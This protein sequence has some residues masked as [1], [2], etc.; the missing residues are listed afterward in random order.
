MLTI[1]VPM[2]G[3]GSRFSTAGYKLP[4]P[5]I[6]VLGECMISR[7]VRNLAPYEPHRFVFIA[8]REHEPYIKKHMSFATNVVYVD[9]VTEGAAC[10]VLLAREFIDD[11][12][13]LIIA[14]SDQLV[15]WNSGTNVEKCEDDDCKIFVRETNNIQDM[16]NRSRLE[17]A[18]ASIAIFQANHPK[19]SYAKVGHNN[20]VTEVAEKKVISNNA[21]VGIYYFEEGR[22]FV[23]GA[24]DMIRKNIRVNGEFYVCPVFNE[25]IA[26]KRSTTI[27]DVRTMIGLGT[28][29]DLEAYVRKYRD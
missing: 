22:F 25:V 8:R 16:I 14:N 12:Q 10:T 11:D 23:E 6:D 29:E 7:V 20:R 5:F 1:V 27:Y 15:E 9:K 18:A 3:L 13:P 19:W 2:A 24:Q 4:K 17:N 26:R 21:T 28:P